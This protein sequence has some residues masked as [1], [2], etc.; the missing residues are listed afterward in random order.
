MDHDAL[1]FR[2]ARKRGWDKG[3]RHSTFVITDSLMAQKIPGGCDL[4]VFRVISH[5]S[6]DEL[7]DYG[8]N[9]FPEVR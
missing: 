3:L 7:V 1:S 8:K 4:K 2:D 6:I 5:A 9:H